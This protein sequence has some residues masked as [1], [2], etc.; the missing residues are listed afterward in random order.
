VLFVV[1]SKA[2]IFGSSSSYKAIELSE[3]P[4]IASLTSAIAF[5]LYVASWGSSDGETLAGRTA[6]IF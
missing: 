6:D 4:L 2:D 3:Q 1:Y 5:L